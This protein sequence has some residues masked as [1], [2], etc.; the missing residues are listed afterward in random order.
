MSN[1]GMLAKNYCPLN[2]T[3]F[4]KDGNLLIKNPP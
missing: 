2:L 1:M 4:K 3:T